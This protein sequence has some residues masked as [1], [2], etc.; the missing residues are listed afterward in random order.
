MVLQAFP[1]CKYLL[2]AEAEVSIALKAFGNANLQDAL[3]YVTSTFH[4][5]AGHGC[6]TTAD[7]ES[8]GA[9]SL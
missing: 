9:L 3:Q 7:V 8:S 6:V 4:D 2:T 5:Q 1:I